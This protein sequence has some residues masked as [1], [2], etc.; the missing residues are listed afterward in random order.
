MTT[1]NA[2]RTQIDGLIQYLIEVGFSDDQNWPFEREID[3][4]TIEVTFPGST[5][6]AIAMKDISYSEIYDHLKSERAYL[7]RMADGALIQMMYIFREQQIERHRLAFYPSP[8]LEKFQNDPDLYLEDEI[9]ADIIAKNIVPFPL[10]FDFDGNDA[11]FVE[12]EHPKS[13]LTLGQYKNC[14]IPVSAPLTPF[15]FIEFVLMNFYHTAHFKCCNSPNFRHHVGGSFERS[16][17]RSEQ[18]IVHIIVPAA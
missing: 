10:R 2:I 8:Y 15:Q 11:A 5:H 18:G 6:I 14:R 17:A 16:I 12:V 7:V 3:N 9:Y 13:H 4:N 1:P